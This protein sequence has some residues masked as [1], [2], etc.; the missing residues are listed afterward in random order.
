MR[1]GGIDH[2]LWRHRLKSHGLA[3]IA[4][5]RALGRRIGLPGVGLFAAQCRAK[6]GAVRLFAAAASL[7]PTAPL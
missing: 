5:G 4:A 1:R 3:E 6:F 2:R 7:T